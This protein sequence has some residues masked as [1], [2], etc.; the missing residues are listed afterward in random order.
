MAGE[1][2]VVAPAALGTDRE[3]DQLVRNILDSALRKRGIYRKDLAKELKVHPRTLRNWL[4]CP[5]GLTAE[6]IE[7]LCACLPIS[8]E[9]RL[10]LRQLTGQRPSMA[11]VR[12]LKGLP[13]MDIYRR[14]IDGCSYPSIV[15]DRAAENVMTNAAYDTMFG[16]VTPH[17]FA[18]PMQSGL[19]YILFH[20]RAYLMLG[21]GD[22]DAF[23]EF[24]L[25]PALAHFSAA[26]EQHPDDA[27]L[28]TM[29]REI[30]RR[31]SLRRAHA[32]TPAW[33]LKSGDIQVNTQPRPF[34]DLRTGELTTVHVVTEGHRGYQAVMLTHTSFIFSDVPTVPRAGGDSSPARARRPAARPL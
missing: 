32:A 4:Q 15:T 26:W 21:G 33:I 31:R 3:H 10:N 17:R 2:D 8:A 11:T 24:W 27:N 18:H 19:K 16:V 6:Q 25:M 7:R 20:P 5:T 34:R 28:L 9:N 13:E 29:E 1:P 12:E 23:R 30:Q 14:V 22:M